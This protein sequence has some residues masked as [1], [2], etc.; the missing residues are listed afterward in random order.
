MALPV[1]LT[2]VTVAGKV[3]GSDAGEPRLV[4]FTQQGWHVGPADDLIVRPFTL[5]ATVASDGS[6]AID[7]PATDDPQW[8][9]LDPYR[10][11]VAVNGYVY[12]GVLAVPYDTVGTL[13]LADHLQP[14]ST[15]AEPL[16]TFLLS[17][18]RGAPGGVAPLDADGDVTDAAGNK[19]TGGGGGGGPSPS[20]TVTAA[21]SYGQSA[22]DGA[23]TTYSR[24]DHTH[25]TPAAVTWSTLSG[26]P[27]TFPP[28][29]PIAQSDVTGLP[30]AL[31]A[32]SGA[33]TALDARL[34]VLEARPAVITLAD[35]AL[36]PGDTPAGTIVV[37][38]DT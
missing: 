2:Y 18:S 30:A 20:N 26:K 8:Q 14:E 3:A 31:T 23:A 37:R 24:G 33:D 13:Q 22:D 4:S 27:S 38:Y 29:L 5:Y 35:G 1:E 9:P 11:Q 7:L 12:Y 36:V 17:A 21:T 25:G 32:L 15:P 28:T 10:V 19:I 6:F 16:S 34:A